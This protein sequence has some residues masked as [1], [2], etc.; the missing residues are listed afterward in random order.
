[1]KILLLANYTADAQESMTR[2][3]RMLET[4]FTQ[5][6]HQVRV[7]R[8]QP[9][10]GQLKVSATGLGKW[11]GYIDKFILFPATLRQA[12]SWADIVHICDHS[13]AI[14]TK[15]LQNTPHLVTCHDLLAIRSALGEIPENPTKWTGQK[16]Q[17]MILNGINQAQHVVCVSEQTQNDLLRLSSL[18]PSQV[19]VIYM[20][21]NYPY[22]PMT[23]TETK[24][25]LETLGISQH[26]PFLLHIGGNHWY[27]NRLGVLSIFYELTQKQEHEHLSLVMAG[28]AWTPA[29]QEFVQQSNLRQKVIEL[30]AID[31]QDLQAL[32]SGATALLFPSLAEGFGWPIIEAQACGCPVI[33]SQKAP[34]TEVGRDTV[35]YI[36]PNSSQ[37]AANIISSHLP[38]IEK[39]KSLGLLNVDRFRFNKLLENYIQLYQKLIS[40]KT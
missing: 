30:V 7:I 19:S 16:L 9:W 14:Y 23:A 37:E 34:M 32:Y 11:L 33:T 31:N 38:T 5:L 27:K 28:Q 2:F 39:L 12:V 1:M 22:S 13:N 20:S 24:Q 10:I 26:L 3:V 18:K 4:G 40:N 6:G 36:D 29:M 21:L 15:Y 17:Q 8:P 25:R 35:I